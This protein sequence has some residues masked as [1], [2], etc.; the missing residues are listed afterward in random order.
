MHG[1]LRAIS[2]LNKNH[3]EFH[4][5]LNA[6][7][8]LSRKQMQT[9]PCKENIE[10]NKRREIPSNYKNKTKKDRER[11]RKQKTKHKKQSNSRK[12]SK[13]SRNFHEFAM[14]FYEFL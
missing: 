1:L 9:K 12:I 4:I 6:L 10:N 5:K 7:Q 2:H 14:N 8:V 3:L 13:I 11:E